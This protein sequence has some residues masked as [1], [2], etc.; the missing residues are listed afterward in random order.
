MKHTQLTTGLIAGLLSLASAA[1][2]TPAVTTP[3]AVPLPPVTSALVAPTI[4]TP[5]PSAQLTN[6]C[7][8]QPVG[9]G[10]PDIVIPDNGVVYQIT[11]NTNCGLITVNGTL[12]CA[13][14]VNAVVKADGIIVAGPNAKLECGTA[15]NRFDGNVTFT[16]RN[17]RSF[18]APSTHGERAFVVM[19]GGTLDLH[20]QL[21]KVRFSRLNQDAKADQ[22]SLLTAGAGGWEKGDQIILTTTSTYFDQTELLTLDDNCPA[23]TC[24]IDSA[25][26]HFHYGGAPKVYPAAGENGQ[27]LVAD[28]RAYLANLER[29]ITIRGANDSYW[30]APRPKGG[31]L[32]IMPGATARIDAVEFQRMGQQKILGRY[33]VHWH[34]AG[35]VTG[36]YLRNS[37]IHDSASRCVAL[38]NTHQADI[39]NNLCYNVVGH[40]IFLENGN[41]IE[42]TLIGNLVVDVI[43]PAVGE[44]LLQ[45][46][47]DVGLS[48]WRGPAGFWIT[49]G[50][51]TIQDNVV[52]NSGSGYWHAYIRKLYCY[53]SQGAPQANYGEFCDYAGLAGPVNVRPINSQTLH[54]KDNVAYS[55][56]IGHTWDGAPDGAQ[57]DP[58]NEFDREPAVTG[59]APGSSQVFDGMHAYKQGKTAI[60]Y[61]GLAKTAHIKNAVVAEAPIGWF[62]TGNQEFFD[63][64]FIGISENYQGLTP[65]DKDLY[66]HADLSIPGVDRGNINNLF[67]GWGLYDGPNHFRNVTF[68][69]PAAPLAPMYLNNKEITPT[70]ITRFGRA[71]FANHLMEQ[72]HFVNDPYRRIS[73]DTRHFG[74]NW[75]DVHASETNY[76]IDGSL[77]GAAGYLRPDDPFNQLAGDCV[78]ESNNADADPATPAS[79]ILRCQTP[80]QSIKFQ[81]GENTGAASDKQVFD[82]TRLDTNATVGNSDPALLFSKFQMYADTPQPIN[83]R[84]TNLDFRTTP[85]KNL[86]WIETLDLGDWTSAMII[87]GPSAAHFAPN[88]SKPS[89][90]VLTNWPGSNIKPVHQALTLDELRTFNDS[91]KSGVFYQDAAS[92]TLIVKLQSTRPLA[93]APYLNNQHKADGKFDLRCL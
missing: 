60:Y 32:M 33:P 37:S 70:P 34:H 18:P 28:M 15:S 44:N 83:Y 19:N 51:N 58:D 21:T 64:V 62:G 25:L 55:T 82:V 75:R 46:D 57:V 43:E 36:Q 86:I 65:A 56:R 26:E 63:S 69:Y 50:N 5:A 67:K 39:R 89:D 71:H 14:G 11:G 29:N 49:N 13:A 22:S 20:G 23:G 27:D 24:A 7:G 10:P 6:L 88:C 40:A 31:H 17:N 73:Y 45:T 52:V 77:F 61:R 38:H 91:S 74:L 90:Y 35:L 87:D 4:V 48:R 66:Y 54:Y 1:Q 84:I 16:L 81:M 80:T 92:G 8:L 93:G 2:V 41:E 59:Y 12:R 3:T 47:I 85:D 42:N 9:G 79:T 53:D 68:D 30:N 78:R 72:I 76:D